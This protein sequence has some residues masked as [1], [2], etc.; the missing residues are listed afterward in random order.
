MEKA[1]SRGRP[2]AWAS[3]V[4]PRREVALLLVA[5]GIMAVTRY[6]P[7]SSL[8][9]VPDASVAIFFL[10][11]FAFRRSRYSAWVFG[12]LFAAGWLIDYTAITVGGTSNW[13]FTPAY[14]FLIPAYGCVWYAGRWCADR[15]G[16]GW[17]HWVSLSAVL[18][19]SV[20]LA[21]LIS[22][23]GFY[24]F[25][26]RYPEASWQVYTAR[27]AAYYPHYVAYAVAYVGLAV[28][29]RLAA[30]LRPDWQAPGL[31]RR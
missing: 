4:S 15:Q 25:S 6:Y 19:I 1:A 7:L 27:V 14:A 28:L 24:L 10:A 12:A 26:G 23:A 17:R 31:P 9:G 16:A 5:I 13:C 22:D 2:A 11:G 30:A 29:L 18:L 20:S 8:L 3:E 21:F